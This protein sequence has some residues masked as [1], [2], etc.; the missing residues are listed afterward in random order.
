MLASDSSGVYNQRIAVDCILDLKGKLFNPE[1]KFSI[2]LPDSDYETQ[3]LVYSQID[4]NNQAQMSEQMIFLLVLNQFKPVS[5]NEVAMYSGVGATSLDILTSQLSN[6]LSQISDD[7][8]I[9]VNYRPGNDITS[10]EIEVALSTQLFNNRVSIDGNFGVAG[11]DE[12]EKASNIVGDVN[13][14]V[15]ITEDGRFR[16][17][18]FNKTN[19]VNSIEYNAPYTQGV[20]VFYRK[21]FDNFSDLFRRKKQVK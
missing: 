8:D 11:T 12:T 17:K 21:E 14:E 16:V 6:W 5:G 4:T 9:G 19:N 10:E 2:E 1:I 13:V 7:F 20:G 18:A 3:Q 15:K